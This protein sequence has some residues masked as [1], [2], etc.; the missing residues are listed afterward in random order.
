MTGLLYLLNVRDGKKKI[1]AHVIFLSIILVASFAGAKIMQFLFELWLYKGED[2]STWEVLKTSGGN[3][4]GGVLFASLA[5]IIYSK[6][7]PQRIINWQ[8]LDTLAMAFPFGHMVGRIGCISAGCCYGKICSGCA[9]T[10]TYPENWPI[11]A[12]A[13]ESIHHGPRIASPLIAAI[14]LFIIGSVLFTILKSTKNRGQVSAL[15]LISYGIFRFFQEFTRGDVRAFFGPLSGHQWFSLAEVLIGFI[16]L[17]LFIRR[18]LAGTAG[19]PF[20]P[21][22]G[23]EPSDKDIFDK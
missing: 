16:L 20:L 10:F 5:I 19:P 15:Y 22:N 4:T 9:L 11:D 3:V 6:F 23:K 8:T 21:F 14:G 17:G 12:F 18:R 2:I 1:G 7:D 13:A